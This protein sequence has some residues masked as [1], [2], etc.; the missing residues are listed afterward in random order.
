MRE[1]ASVVTLAPPTSTLRVGNPV[2]VTSTPRGSIQVRP[3][4]LSPKGMSIGR[5]PSMAATEVTLP[6]PRVTDSVVGT[7]AN[8]PAMGLIGRSSAGVEGSRSVPSQ[9]RRMVPMGARSTPFWRMSV[10]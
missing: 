9:P 5:P 1:P 3:S 7:G 6:E 2:K 4:G 8:E 10:A